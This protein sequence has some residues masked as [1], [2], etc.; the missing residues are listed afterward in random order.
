MKKR[1]T[2]SVLMAVCMFVPIM[3][4]SPSVNKVPDNS[5]ATQS[6][7]SIQVPAE[8]TLVVGTKTAHFKRFTTLSPDSIVGSGETDVRYFSLAAS[9]VYNY[10]VSQASKVTYAGTFKMSS[11][12]APLSIPAELLEGDPRRID[13]DLKAN[14]NFNVADIL[15]NINE[16]GHL[17]LTTGDSYQLVT[18]RAWQAVDNII[19][20]YFIDPDYRYRV[21][22]EEGQADATVVTVDHSGRLSAVGTGTAIVL[23]SYDAINSSTAAGGPFFGALWPENTGVFVVTVGAQQADVLTGMKLNEAANAATIESKL[24]GAAIDAEL[25]VLYYP[26]ADGAYA[27]TFTPESGAVVTLAKPVITGDELSYSGFSANGVVPNTDGSFTTQLVNGPN[28]IRIATET[29]VSYQVLRAKP[30]TYTLTNLSAPEAAIHPGDEVTVL[31]NSVFHPVHKLAGVYNMSARISYQAATSTVTG[32]ANQYTFAATAKAQTLTFTIPDN[33]DTTQPFLLNGGAILASGYGD[34]Y[35][36]HRGITLEKGKDVN[37]GALMRKA[38]FGALPD[39]A[40]PVQS[41][42]S[43]GID[44]HPAVRL[45]VYPNPFTEVLTVQTDSAVPARIYTVSG[46]LVVETTLQEGSN[47]I[48]VSNLAQGAY[49]IHCGDAI[50]RIV[51]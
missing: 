35:G 17:K 42:I 41:S 2:L 13:R 1:F 22:N 40:I 16:R 47:R 29:A 32:A 19:N 48:D 51:K 6:V 18:I 31:F 49:V 10:R 28:I 24:A 45:Q 33:W 50:Q 25:D 27:Y 7:Y 38:Y 15:L 20:N 37:F 26:E 23:V 44:Q 43:T 34:P 30:V 46:Q 21:M 5:T 12:L 14:S 8:A 39:I 9:Q 3:A 11:T 36:G 4:D